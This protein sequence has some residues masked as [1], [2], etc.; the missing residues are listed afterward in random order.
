MMDEFDWLNSVAVEPVGDVA[1][2]VDVLLWGFHDPVCWLSES[3][4]RQLVTVLRCRLDADADQVQQALA[5]C[6]TYLRVAC[7]GVHVRLV[8]G[9]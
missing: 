1:D 4:V 5:N 8:T 2:V 6:A 7:G 9:I 3:E